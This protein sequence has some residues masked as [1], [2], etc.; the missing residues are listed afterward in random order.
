MGNS[1]ARENLGDGYG[2]AR[3]TATWAYSAFCGFT[4]F[5]LVA[6]PFQIAM[7]VVFI[8]VYWLIIGFGFT[9]SVM[10]AYLTQGLIVM[11]TVHFFLDTGVSVLFGRA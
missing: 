5:Q 4:P 9:T 3:S 2:A 1:L 8:I 11:F 6:L 7:M 10:A